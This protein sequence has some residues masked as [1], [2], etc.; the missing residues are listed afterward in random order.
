MWRVSKEEALELIATNEDISLWLHG[1]SDKTQLSYARAM[2]RYIRWSKLTPKKLL[3]LKEGGGRKAE[4]LLDRFAA[5]SEMSESSK[6]VDVAAVH[7]F[8]V[9]NYLDLAKKSGY[10]KVRY[11]KVKDY[12]CPTQA[13]LREM[14]K[15]A[16]IRDDAIVNAISSGGFRE[17]TTSLL[18]WGDLHEIW[19]WDGVTPIYVKVDSKRL[20][21]EGYKGKVQ[22]HTFLTPYAAQVHLKY[23]E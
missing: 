5:A 17:E 6:K 22:Q 9:A 16:H 7:S 21:G 23:A 10:S 11:V 15:N 19:D 13:E 20:K 12:K 1:K 18:V 14:T 4:R 8:Y 2:T 3:E